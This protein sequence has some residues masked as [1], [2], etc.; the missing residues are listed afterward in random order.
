MRFFVCL[1]LACAFASPVSAAEPGV[2]GS[3]DAPV[4]VTELAPAK[5]MMLGVFH[6]ANP[7]RDVVKSEV[8]D[9]TAAENQAYLAALATRLAAF[10]PTDV[11]TECLRSAQPRHDAAYAA[12]RDDG[13]ALSV[14][15]TQQ[16]GYR[17]AKEAGL[18]GVTCFD[19][20]EVHWNGGP[21]FA[22]IA[23]HDPAR[24][25]EMDAVFAALSTRQ[26]REQTTLALPELLRLSN[27]P[28]RDRE[29]KNLYIATNAADAGGGFVGADAS[30]SWWHRNFRMYANV[31]R[32]A[33][34]GR[35]VLVIA[36][37]GHT[38]ILK[39]LLAIDGERQTEDVLPYLAP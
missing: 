5:V 30:A 39:D 20:G 33:A 15:E 14:N 35:R 26:T 6:F 38:A 21:L 36:G 22:Y 12:Y 34:P 16:I 13:A 11:L 37:S 1:A 32:A 24:K 19:E 27:D 17:V 7:G 28:E 25:A 29:N 4:P 23:E 3:T 8:I 31:Q 10:G 9:V 18:D 2:E